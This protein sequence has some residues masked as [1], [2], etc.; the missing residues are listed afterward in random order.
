MDTTSFDDLLY[1]FGLA[2]PLSVFCWA[3][4]FPATGILSD[5]DDHSIVFRVAARAGFLPTGRAARLIVAAAGLAFANS[6][7]ILY[8]VRPAPGTP[9]GIFLIYFLVQ[10]IWLAT[11]VRDILH[12]RSRDRGR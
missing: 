1:L 7:P 12:A 3:V 11:V 9:T 6:V 5:H 4:L 2:L 10:G 8:L